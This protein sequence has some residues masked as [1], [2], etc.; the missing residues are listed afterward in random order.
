MIPT[1]I[2][3]TGI[4]TSGKSTWIKNNQSKWK[5]TIVV[6]PDELRKKLLGDVNDQ[7]C[8]SIIFKFA[9]EIII[10]NL[11]LGK[12]VVLD[13]TNTDT[14]YRISFNDSITKEV[15]CKKIA[16]I[17]HVSL[18]ESRK[19][20]IS[21]IKNNIDRCHVSEEVLDIQYQLFKE[22]LKSLPTESFEI[23]TSWEE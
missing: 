15:N 7:S 9:K 4:P 19:R 3:L 13:S 1:L 8:N 14:K 10:H 5:N 20:I 17:F 22:T 12:N 11:K 18:K 2:E 21:D 6:S 23:V 16:L